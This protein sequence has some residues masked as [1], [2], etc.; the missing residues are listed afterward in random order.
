MTGDSVLGCKS[1]GE[2]HPVG[3]GGSLIRTSRIMQRQRQRFDTRPVLPATLLFVRSCE[4]IGCAAVLLP[5]Q[6]MFTKERPH[7]TRCVDAAAGRS[8]EPFRQ[9]LATK[10]LMTSSV[11]GVQHHVRVVSTIRVLAA[12]DISG[13]RRF[14]RVGPASVSPGPI[15]RPGQDGGKRS[16]R[17]PRLTAVVKSE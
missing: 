8:D 12:G 14:N 17:Y 5:R 10:P 2:S 4:N 16:G 1:T 11:D 3:R 15:R 9:R 13:H 6:L 7:L